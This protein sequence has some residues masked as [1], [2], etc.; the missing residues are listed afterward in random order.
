MDM[1]LTGREVDAREAGS[2]GLVNRVCAPGKALDTAMELAAQIARMPQQCMRSDRASAY[3]QWSLDSDAALKNEFRRAMD[4]V[5]GGEMRQ[6][7]KRFMQGEGRH[8]R[9]LGDDQGE[10]E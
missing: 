1:I 10:D 9:I 5:T 8:G 3:E 4:V 6:G 2:M 7:V